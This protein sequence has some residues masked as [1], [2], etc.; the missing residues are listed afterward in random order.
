[1]LVFPFWL[2]NNKNWENT[3][4]DPNATN[5]TLPP[6]FLTEAS[7]VEPY[8]KIKVQFAMFVL[9]MVL[10]GLS[11]VFIAGVVAWAWT[12]SEA[13][14]KTSSFPLFDVAFRADVQNNIDN[15]DLRG[16]SDSEIVHLMRDARA[17]GRYEA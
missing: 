7:I 13:P 9:F 2:F 12:R 10:Q 11:L 17:I 15:R 5:S 1:M 16:L 6:E 14:F 3:N 8:A 4:W